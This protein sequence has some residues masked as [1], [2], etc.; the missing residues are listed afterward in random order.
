[1][2]ITSLGYLQRELFGRWIWILETKFTVYGAWGS[3]TEDA[4]H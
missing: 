1:M 3:G 2:S 4:R